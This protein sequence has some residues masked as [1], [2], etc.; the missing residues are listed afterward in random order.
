M[1]ERCTTRIELMSGINIEACNAVERDGLSL[2]LLPF[3]IRAFSRP[4]AFDGSLGWFARLAPT[5]PCASPIERPLVRWSATYV[6]RYKLNE[7]ER[8]DSSSYYAPH[9]RIPVDCY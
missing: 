1:N 7:M 8:K 3:P 6:H 5:V 9:L 4:M 2:P